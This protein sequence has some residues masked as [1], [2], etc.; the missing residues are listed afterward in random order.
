MKKIIISGL[1]AG[2]AMLVVGLAAG[3]LLMLIFPSLAAEYSNTASFGPG[4]IRSCRS[5]ACPFLIGF[6]LAWVWN[7]VKGVV[8]A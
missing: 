2:V 5:I 7:K 1:L 8:E 6:I 4:R 3:Y